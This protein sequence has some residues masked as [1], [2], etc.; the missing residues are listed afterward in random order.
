MI[1]VLIIIC[2]FLFLILILC[3]CTVADEAD[4]YIDKNINKHKENE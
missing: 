2:A 1:S 3:L 4:A